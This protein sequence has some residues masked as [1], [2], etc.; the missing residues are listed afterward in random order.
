MHPV[1]LLATFLAGVQAS[2]TFKGVDWSSLLIEEAAGYTYKTTAGQTAPLE[3]ILKASGVNT[4]RQRLWVNPTNGNYNLDYNLKLAKRAK[5]AGLNV[6]LDIFFSDTWA[7]PANQKIPSGWPTA[8]G[9][10][11]WEAYNYTLDVSNAFAAAG[12]PLSIVSIGNEITG[13]LLFPTGSTSSFY[14]LATI[15]HSASSGIKYSNLATKPKIMIHLDNGWK[16]DTQQWWYKGVLAAGPLLTT[17][18]DMMGVS[19]YPFY[20]PS[21]TL[22]NLKTTLTNMASTWKKSIVVAETNWPVT[23]T[24]P[25]YAFPADTTSIPKSAAGQTTWMKDVA[26]IVAGV[27]GGS[28]LFYWE[29]AWIQNAGLGSSCYDNLMVDQNGVARSSL[30]VFASI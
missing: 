30:G 18:F 4:V 1:Y 14:N 7:D 28:G 20:N 5:A 17:D 26:S 27:S 2:L 12:V 24:S 16:W 15:L 23:C 13:G 8:V 9:D 22:A 6:Y 29:P 10:L 21:A 11:A 25:Q 3:T 19:Y